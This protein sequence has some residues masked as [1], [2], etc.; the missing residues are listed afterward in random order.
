M[1][2]RGRVDF[3]LKNEWKRVETFFSNVFKN[4]KFCNMTISFSLKHVFILVDYATKKI[5]DIRYVV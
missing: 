1:D 5:I 4:F 2:F 3:A